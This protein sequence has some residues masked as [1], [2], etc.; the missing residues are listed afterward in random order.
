M[1]PVNQISFYV[2]YHTHMSDH[3]MCRE[4]PLPLHDPAA[5]SPPGEVVGLRCGE[6]KQG[7][8]AISAWPDPVVSVGRYLAC[9]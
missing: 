3:A 5:F 9:E 2:L 4:P 1:V 7:I 6:R 8:P